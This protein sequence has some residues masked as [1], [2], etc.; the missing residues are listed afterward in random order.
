MLRRRP[1]KRCC[2]VALFRLLVIGSSCVECI[3]GIC[4]GLLSSGMLKNTLSFV[5][6]LSDT[7]D[8]NS[9]T[10]R[11]RYNRNASLCHRPKSI[12]VDV[13]TPCR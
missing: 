6:I 1:L 10:L 5:I 12:I 7:P 13:R 9:L 4:W 8:V 11:L 2:E 3:C